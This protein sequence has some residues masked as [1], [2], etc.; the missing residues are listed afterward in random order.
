MLR[1]GAEAQAGKVNHAGHTSCKVQSQSW[2][3]PP[4]YTSQ[5][6]LERPPE[7]A[8]PCQCLLLLATSL[9]SPAE[10][11]R[12]PVCV[13]SISLCHGYFRGQI[14]SGL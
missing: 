13:C 2:P 9:W 1:W 4:S 6:G 14:L 12:E 5:Q 11:P 3:R 8:L 10:W 7:E